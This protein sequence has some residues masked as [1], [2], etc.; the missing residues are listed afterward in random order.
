MIRHAFVAITLATAGG[1][2]R[3]AA[4][5]DFLAG[6]DAG[7]DARP[8]LGDGGGSVAVDG[9]P[10]AS[11]NGRSSGTFD[12]NTE[13]TGARSRAAAGTMSAQPRAIRRAA[14][15]TRGQ[16][17]AIANA[18]VRTLA[19]IARVNTRARDSSNMSAE[20]NADRGATAQ[21][22]AAIA[23]NAQL[24]AHLRSAGIVIGSIVGAGV[25]V[26]GGLTLHAAR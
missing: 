11:A 8:D 17:A 25:G 1:A 9:S 18:G 13:V 20:A 5:L 2:V 6:A 22:H 16:L 19:T 7:S 3:P 4:A 10:G 12:S 15:A 24:R 21:L 23:A 26:E 14:V